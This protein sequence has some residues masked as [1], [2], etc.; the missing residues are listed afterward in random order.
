MPFPLARNE[1]REREQE[2]IYWAGS[3]RPGVTQQPMEIGN[4]VESVFNAIAEE[5]AEG[6]QVAFTGFGTFT[7]KDRPERPGRNPQTG[8]AIT[9][10]A[11]K[12]VGFKA[13]K[14]LQER[15]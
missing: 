2:R 8:A 15:L 7:V 14:K 12:T 13:A 5:L 10:A 1:R 11:K 9:I 4:V 3:A 6:N